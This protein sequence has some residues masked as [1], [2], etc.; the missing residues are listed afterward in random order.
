VLFF[1]G[2][3]KKKRKE[4]KAK[5]S[6]NLIKF[7]NGIMKQWNRRTRRCSFEEETSVFEIIVFTL[8]AGRLSIKGSLTVEGY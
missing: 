8:S 6:R 7:E 5:T 2:K 4:L 1:P 3:G